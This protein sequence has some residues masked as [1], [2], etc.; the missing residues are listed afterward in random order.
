MEGELFWELYPL[1][2]EEAKL[3]GRPKW[4]QISDVMIV[5]VFFWAVLHDRPIAWACE[6]RHWPDDWDG[7][8]LPSAAT[9]SRRLRRLS[10]WRLITGVYDR[11]RYVIPWAWTLCWRIDTKPLVVGGFS[12]DRDARRGYATGGMARG[13]KL[14]VVWAKSVVPDAV[15]IAPLNVS[16]PSCAVNLIDQMARRNPQASGYLLAD[17]THDSNPLH[18][19]A[20]A[21]SFQLLT[22]RKKPGTE[23]GHRDHS[24]ARLRSI[25]M[26]EG[27]S[28]FG[29][30]LYQER[31]NIE[32]DLA[33]LCGFGGGLQPLPSWVRHPRRIARWVIA[34]LIINGLRQC[35][36]K[37]VAA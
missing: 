20:A 18:E 16:D 28:P 27:P 36:I 12:K 21:H 24:P 6:R 8:E 3:C 37:G 1:V 22:P 17:A 23:L 33:H 11:L 4:V 13:Y 9:M 19:Y 2:Q 7:P 30:S 15:T 10:C 31:G 14:A 25:E 34:K 35:K 26:L 32:R 5:L 29:K